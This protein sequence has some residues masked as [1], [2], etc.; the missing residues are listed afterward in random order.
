MKNLCRLGPI[1]AAIIGLM[2]VAP[3]AKVQGQQG[4]AAKPTL[5]VSIAGVNSLLDNI[6]Y[7]TRVVGTPEVGGLVTMMA[8]QYI[9]GLDT[10]RPVGMFIVMAGPQ[11]TGVVFLPVSDFAAVIA[12]IEES[13]GE[14]EDLGGGVRK[15]SVQRDIFFK[16]SNGWA[17]VTD[18]ASNLENLPDDPSEM[19]GTLPQD[20]EVAVR[21]N[22]QSIPGSLREMAISQIREGFERGLEGSKDEDAR[23]LQQKIGQ[24]S[25]KNLVSFIEE[26]DQLTVGW[27][28]DS[29]EGSTYLDV[30]LSAL[31]GSKLTE[32][33]ALLSGNETEFSGFLLPEAAAKL[34][35][36]SRAA[37]EDIEQT[38]LVLGMMRD[39]VMEGIDDD[40]ELPNDEARAKAKEIVG[41]FIQ[42]IE[43]TVASGRFDGGAALLLN[44]GK[45]QLVGGGYLV[46]GSVIEQNLKELVELGKSIEDDEKLDQIK[47]NAESYQGINLHTATVPIPED[48]DDARKVFG[49]ELSIVVGTGAKSAY[50]AL[51]TDCESLLKTVIDRSGSQKVEV[52]VPVTFDIALAPILEFAAAIENE[53]EVKRLAESLQE[54][55][56]KDH[57]TVTTATGPRSV[58]YRILVQEGVL[59]LIGQ[60]AKRGR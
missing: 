20:Y 55:N 44:D 43:D 21:V 33:L 32:R 4:Q 12:K 56:G 29:N 45:L 34:H 40:D 11:P 26:A 17:F 54:S 10:K 41:A 3:A 2:V 39:K 48:E 60:A 6:G 18:S 13:L 8:G 15:I 16:E 47:F 1:V 25:I 50:V 49:S 42:V 7:L 23:E 52:K 31:P 27:G 57:I 53:P 9:Q 46:D 51:G 19:L 37:E 22:V 30:D 28:V 36:T 14:P 5:V 38:K 59:N 24:H 58:S 35:F